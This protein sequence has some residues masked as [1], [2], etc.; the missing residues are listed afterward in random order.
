MAAA[1]SGASDGQ[2][3]W[4]AIRRAMSE[5]VPHCQEIGIQVEALS[6]VPGASSRVLARLPWRATF[7]RGPGDAR[8]HGGMIAT[9]C[10]SAAGIAAFC[11]L[12]PDTPIATLEL[13]LDHV[14]APGPGADVTVACGCTDVSSGLVLVRGEAADAATGAVVARMTATFAVTPRG[15]AI[16]SDA[17]SASVAAG[18]S[19]PRDGGAVSSRAAPASFARFLGAEP[20]D[21]AT[22]LVP[23][24]PGLIGNVT[25][26]AL[27]GGVAA[28]LLDLAVIEAVGVAS[29]GDATADVAS[30]TVTYLR[31]ARPQDLRARARILRRGQSVVQ[32]DAV[33]WQ[34]SP[35]KPV[36]AATAT[37]RLA[38]R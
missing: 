36:A 16:G 17:A 25:L 23:F 7:A 18:A 37:V 10:D 11:A 32:L 13:R 26:P 34:D 20:R 31:L 9:L 14:G 12:P 33:A 35:D 28:A 30:L 21:G 38:S 29:P 19:G 1:T 3:H 8:M 4:A 24:R 6:G 22:L 15:F 27:H 2:A 5:T